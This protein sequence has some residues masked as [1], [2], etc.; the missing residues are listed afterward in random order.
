ML[1]VRA[2]IALLLVPPAIC[3][4]QEPG[5]EKPGDCYL[6]VIARDRE[7]QKR[8]AVEWTDFRVLT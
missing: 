6:Q 4:G 1:A 2:L 3:S 7:E 5:P 8:V